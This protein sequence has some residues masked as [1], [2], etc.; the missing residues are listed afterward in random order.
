MDQLPV[1]VLDLAEV[2]DLLDDGWRDLNLEQ[3]LVVI[4]Q[5]D[6][7]VLRANVVD[8][9]STHCVVEVQIDPLRYVQLVLV[10]AFADHF[11][12]VVRSLANV[13]YHVVLRKLGQ[14]EVTV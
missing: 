11:N 1:S 8:V 5:R 10:I 13:R 9:I 2:D 3:L 7:R 6:D 12:H 4:N 14:D